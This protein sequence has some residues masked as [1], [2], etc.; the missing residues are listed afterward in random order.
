MLSPSYPSFPQVRLPKTCRIRS[1]SSV[2]FFYKRVQRLNHNP[3]YNDLSHPPA[4]AIG[5]Q[6]AWRAADG[7]SNNIDV[8]DMGKSNTP[9]AR[10]VQQT[11]P[12]P[13]NELPDPGLIFDTSVLFWLRDP[14]L[15]IVYQSLEEGEGRSDF[16]LQE[17]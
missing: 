12:L 17:D 16:D 15:I 14:S 13:I 2:S 11:H 5:N 7:G 6:Y 10:S 1:F 8:P 4:T 3:V 9:Y